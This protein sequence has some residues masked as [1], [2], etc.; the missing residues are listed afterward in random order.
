MTGRSIETALGAFLLL[1]DDAALRQLW[2]PSQQEAWP[3]WEPGDSGVLREAAAQLTAY[4]EGR[5]KAFDLPLAPEG[6]PFQRRVWAALVDIPYGATCSYRAIAERIGAPTAV[7]AVGAAN[8]RNPLP[9]VLPCHRV[10]GASGAL[11]GYGGGLPF[12]R[13]LLD[14]ERGQA[15][16]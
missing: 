2:L 8:G 11:T 3:A 15:S 9:V 16:L 1:G 14:L 4:C 12:K 7:R 13:R 6:T 5:R 10:I